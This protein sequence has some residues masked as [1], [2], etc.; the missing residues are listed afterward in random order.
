VTYDAHAVQHAYDIIAAGYADT[1]SDD[2]EQITVDRSVIDDA[3]ASLPSSSLFIDLGCGPAQVARALVARGCRA[4]GLDLTPGMLD[5]ARQQNPRLPLVRGDVLR[6][7]IRGASVDGVVAWFSLHNLPRGLVTDALAEV[8]RVLREGAVLMIATHAG[9]GEESV[10][11]E[12]R[13][14][15]ERVVITYYEPD[16]L[17][18]LLTD[19]GFGAIEC[20]SRP[21]LDHEH[22]VTKVFVT[23]T[24]VV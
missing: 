23:A 4:I 7:P 18:S 1:F 9:S 21:P 15:T 14:G 20:R 16:E 5:A 8:R 3:I 17:V 6:L 24:A 12:W 11:H 2:L 10:Q 19:H 22:A 13:G